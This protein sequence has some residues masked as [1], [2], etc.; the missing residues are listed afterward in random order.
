MTLPDAVL[1]ETP[2]LI[3]LMSGTSLD[4]IAAAAVRFHRN[5]DGD[6]AELLAFESIAYD[7]TRRTRL[8]AA[9]ERGSARDYCRL[10]VDL[11]HWLA[12]AAAR[13]MERASLS[14][15]DVA[16][17][18]SH[19]Q[20]LWHEPGHSTWQIGDASV[21]AERL[22]TRVIADFR[23]RDVAAGGQ[24]APLVSLADVQLFAAR[25]GWRALQNL[26]GIG[27]VTVVPPLGE[28][29]PT[30]AFDTGPGCGVIDRVVTALDGTRT[31]DVDGRMAAAGEPIE[32][33]LDPL[34]SDD[35]YAIAPPKSTGRE[36][37]DA[38]FVDALVRACRASGHGVRDEDIVAT[39]TALTA[40]TMAIGYSRFVR[41][42]LHDVVLSGGGARNP[43]LVRM[44]REALRSRTV[45]TFDELFFDGEA[46]EAVAFAYIAL[47]HLRG[48]AG[49]VP[50][51]TGAHGPRILGSR[52]LP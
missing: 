50:M 52:T 3:G 47:Q 28:N 34:L 33:I 22:G 36:K 46:K 27:N 20:T 31:C 10:N 24:G 25:D 6:R 2:I 48:S 16:A 18:A 45:R 23:S 5:A 26:G 11:G 30:L 9:M 13:V 19:G 29:L 38:A 21:I 7:E 43:T 1:P 42:D 51:A 40:R 14:A 17:V 44:I 4:G 15:S 12:D 8:S 39:A 41:G 49:N 35:W 32:A 37:Y